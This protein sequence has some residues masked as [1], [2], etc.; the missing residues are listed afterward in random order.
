MRAETKDAAY[1]AGSEIVVAIRPEK[2]RLSF[3]VPG[4]TANVVQGRMGPVAYLG[5]RSHLY[6]YLTG[7]EEPVAVAMQNVGRSA[8]GIDRIDQPVWLSWSDDAIVLL[9]GD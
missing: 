1:E 2:L 8:V 5:D 9:S 4:D 3:E 7:R 6:V